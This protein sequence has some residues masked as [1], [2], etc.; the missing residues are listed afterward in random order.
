M[1]ISVESL[2]RLKGEH[3]A[4]RQAA[5]ALFGV[6][7]ENVLQCFDF[8]QLLNDHIRWE[9]RQLYPEIEQALSADA[10]AALAEETKVIDA[11]HNICRNS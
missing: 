7:A 2:E 3:D 1:P 9:E 6:S 4:L 8:G 11:R 5:G 10:L